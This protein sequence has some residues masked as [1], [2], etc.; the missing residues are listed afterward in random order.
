M[1]AIVVPGRLGIARVAGSYGYG[2]AA[3]R[4]RT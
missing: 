4:R 2:V 1:Q 3:R